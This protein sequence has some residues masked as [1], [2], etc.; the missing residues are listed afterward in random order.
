MRA[1][2]PPSAAIVE[3][4]PVRPARRGATS[5]CAQ[6]AAQAAAGLFHRAI[7]Q[8]DSCANPVQAR[9][10]ATEAAEELACGVGCADPGTSPPACHGARER[11]L[12]P[13][14]PAISSPST[15]ATRR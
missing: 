15:S 12:P 4:H 7:M 1:T 14:T 5:V 3:R 2:R 9:A 6:L 10:E 8:S 11:T 13:F